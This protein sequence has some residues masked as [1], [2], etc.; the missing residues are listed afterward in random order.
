MRIERR[1][2]VLHRRGLHLHM[3]QIEPD[4]TKLLGIILLYS[5]TEIYV[6]RVIWA[7]EQSF[8]KELVLKTPENAILSGDFTDFEYLN[9]LL[10]A[11][12]GE[13]QRKCKSR[14]P[15]TRVDK[16]HG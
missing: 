16:V 7:D 14:G 2:S 8:A 9:I 3:G 13:R 11:G 10:W 6:F 15:K 1:R 5:V 12:S 4:V